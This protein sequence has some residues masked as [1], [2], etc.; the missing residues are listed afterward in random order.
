MGTSSDRACSIVEVPPVRMAVDQSA[1][2]AQLR[3]RPLEFV[4]R[5]RWRLRREHGESGEA[6]R[7]LQRLRKQLPHAGMQEGFL[8]GNDPGDR[9]LRHYHRLPSRHRQCANPRFNR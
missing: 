4:G 5:V 2:E 6:R 8:D 7:V 9:L 1:L 3:D